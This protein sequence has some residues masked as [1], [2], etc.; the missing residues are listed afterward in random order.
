MRRV[1]LGR[2]PDGRGG[3]VAAGAQGRRPSPESPGGGGGA[4]SQAPR[5]RTVSR[6]PGGAPAAP[7]VTPRKQGEGETRA[8]ERGKVTQSSK[9]M[10]WRNHLLLRMAR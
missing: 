4:P 10:Y 3:R 2:F 1:R 7:T 9:R 5:D 6:E 8:A